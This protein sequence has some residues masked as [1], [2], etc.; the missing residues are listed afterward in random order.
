MGQLR[1]RGRIWWVRYYRN[2]KRHEE[3]SHSTR[4]GDA[5]DLLKIREGD[6]AKGLPVTA[7]AGQLRFDEAAADVVTDY[8]V[9][10]KRSLRD[11]ERRIRLHLEPVFGGRRMTSITTADARAY[12]GARQEAGAANATINRELAILKRAF[13]L[14]E[15]AGK[16]LHRPFIPMLAEDNVRKGFFERPEFEDVRAALPAEL[17]GVAAFAFLTGWRVPSE[18]LT[19]QWPQVDRQTKTVRLEPGTT[20]NRD[21]RTFPYALLPE[22]EEVIEHQWAD[23]QHLAAKGTICPYVF[24]R[25]GRPIKS[26]RRAWDKA[27]GE[28]GVPGRIPH[29]FRRTAVRNLVR[30]GVPDVVAMK[31]TGH[32]TRS[33]FDRYNVVAEADLIEAV[34]KLAAKKGTEKGQSEDFGRVRDFPE[35]S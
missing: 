11:V 25:S 20:K 8:T 22:L 5:A 34:G 27:C 26:I 33:V 32:K 10:G 4:K 23:H 30:S 2:G 19:L 7:R 12:T 29:D 24:H 14:A 13:R 21:G 6:I 18:I 28:A 1:Q 35:S 15:Q 16:L 17:Q 3:S 31:L 9:N